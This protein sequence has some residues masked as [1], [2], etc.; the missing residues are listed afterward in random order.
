MTNSPKP[1]FG[2][3]GIRAPYPQSLTPLDCWRLAYCLT[4]HLQKNQPHRGVCILIA[5]DPRATSSE[6]E[7]LAANA[8]ATLPNAQSKHIGI[9]TP[10]LAALT[11]T[12]ND[13]LDALLYITASHNPHTDNGFKIFAAD[14]Q[15]FQQGQIHQMLTFW[16]EAIA[17]LPD[18]KPRTN[19]KAP[20]RHLL[21]A[22]LERIRIQDT[23]A[24]PA[25]DGLHLVV[26]CAN[27]AASQL[28]AP[29]F[30]ARG[31]Q[32]TLCG[33]HPN[34]TNINAGVGTEHP[35]HLLDQLRHHNGQLGIAFDGDADR[36]LIYTPNGVKLDGDLLL[37]LQAKLR[38]QSGLPIPGIVGTTFSNGGLEVALSHLQVDFCRAEVGDIMV[39]QELIRRNWRLGG[40]PSGHLID[41]DRSPVADG[42]LSSIDLIDRLQQHLHKRQATASM[43]MQALLHQLLADYTAIPSKQLTFPCRQPAALADVP[44]LQ[45]LLRQ[46]SQQLEG[47]RLLWRPS[48]TQKVFRILAEHPNNQLLDKVTTDLSDKIQHL[49]DL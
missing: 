37:Y 17:A 11:L 4:R 13:D 10:G 7:Q 23:K 32:V 3:D 44:S 18:A 33:H 35:Q 25:W 27:G 22:T 41:L 40:E 43:S 9:C 30:E 28:A 12:Q 34:G 29:L 39:T 2:T 15:K 48:G 19:Q 6:I 49:T 20:A 1:T 31:A 14:G 38:K 26:D 16:P 46:A 47:G 45:Q 36:L 8:I 21:E 5:T 42:I 24:R